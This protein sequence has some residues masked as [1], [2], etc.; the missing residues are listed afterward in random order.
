MT[1][2]TELGRAL[3]SPVAHLEGQTDER[4]GYYRRILDSLPDLF[5]QARRPAAG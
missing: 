3:G 5:L 1:A 2:I 4:R